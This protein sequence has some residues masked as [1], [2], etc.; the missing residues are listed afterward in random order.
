[1]SALIH[2]GQSSQVDS[3]EFD[4]PMGTGG[5]NEIVPNEFVEVMKEEWEAKLL[6]LQGWICELL[7]K[8]QQLRVA[9]MESNVR[10]PEGNHGPQA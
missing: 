7:I 3:K 8:N 9:L 6:S 2:R 1:M 4:T 5:S 10:Q